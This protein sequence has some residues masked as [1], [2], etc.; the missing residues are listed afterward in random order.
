M[1]RNYSG[2]VTMTRGYLVPLDHIPTYDEIKALETEMLKVGIEGSEYPVTHRFAHKIYSRELFMRKGMRLVGKMHKQ[3]HF[4]V[5]LSGEVTAWTDQGMRRMKAPQI[6]RTEVGTKRV[7]AAHEDSLI[8]TFHGT[9]M[10][11]P[12]DV[13][14]EVIVRKEDERQF[15]EDNGMLKLEDN[16]NT[17]QEYLEICP[18]R[19]DRDR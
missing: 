6:F 10:T 7:I 13:E 11:N 5:L 19:V 1:E 14:A 15:L 4:F 8:A 12:D 17:P 9:E 16:A 2:A 3:T 18:L